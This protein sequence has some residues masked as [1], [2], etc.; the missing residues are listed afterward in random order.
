MKDRAKALAASQIAMHNLNVMWNSCAGNIEAQD[1]IQDAMGFL[2]DARRRFFP[3]EYRAP[4]ML[5]PGQE[6]A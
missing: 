1:C 6:A 5:E 4:L 3:G 2:F